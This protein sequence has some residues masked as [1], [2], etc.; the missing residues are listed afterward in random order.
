M[1]WDL[2]ECVDAHVPLGQWG[3]QTVQDHRCLAAAVKH[4]NHPRSVTEHFGLSGSRNNLHAFLNWTAG[5][6]DAHAAE[7]CNLMVK[8]WL[9]LDTVGGTFGLP[10][11]NLTGENW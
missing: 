6:F 9:K 2:I 8:S 4:G 7:N 5:A 10:N 3:C 11:S 1:D